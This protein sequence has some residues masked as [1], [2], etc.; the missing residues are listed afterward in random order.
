MAG[1][2]DSHPMYEEGPAFGYDAPEVQ[3]HYTGRD[4]GQVSAFF[5][6]RLKPGMN[7]LDCGCGPGTLTLGLAQ[8]VDPGQTTGIDI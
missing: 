4:F 7:V 3:E 8:A 6:D 1:S 5:S 2:T